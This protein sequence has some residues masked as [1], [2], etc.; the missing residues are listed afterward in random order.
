MPSI[1]DYKD[2]IIQIT[3]QHAEETKIIFFSFLPDGVALSAK[4]PTYK[5][6]FAWIKLLLSSIS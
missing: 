6:P 1:C 5:D 4:D 3:T 2:G